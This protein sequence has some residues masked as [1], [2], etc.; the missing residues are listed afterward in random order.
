MTNEEKRDLKID[1]GITIKEWID[2][3]INKYGAKEFFDMV[4]D[5]WENIA[6]YIKES[7]LNE[8]NLK[9]K[10]EKIDTIEDLAKLLDGNEYGD[11]LYNEHNINIE[12]LCKKNKW[13]VVFAYSDDCLELR[14]AIDDELGAWDGTIVKFIK[15]GDFYLD[16][17]DDYGDDDATYRKATQDMV[18]NI[19]ERELDH[20][21]NSVG[22]L[23]KYDG[24][25]IE[26]LWDPSNSDA[27]WQMNCKGNVEYARFNIMEEEELYAECLIIDVSKLM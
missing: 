21:K 7:I 3:N 22:D 9:V 23:A 1:N 26:A 5:E 18:V 20:I 16:D 27:S 19:C 25:I 11:E 2:Y 15:A 24:L 10:P 12:E 4:N 17:C 14:G 6:P 8:I 13:I